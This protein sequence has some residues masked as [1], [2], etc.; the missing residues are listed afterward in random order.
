MG[1]VSLNWNLKPQGKESY[2]KEDVDKG[3]RTESWD[4]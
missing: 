3:P 2:K 4:I 1:A